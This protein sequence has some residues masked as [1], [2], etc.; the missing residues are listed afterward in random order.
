M[1]ELIKFQS[2]GICGSPSLL[3][4]CERCKMHCVGIEWMSHVLRAE[5]GNFVPCR[6]S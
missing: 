3:I 2:L 4:R 5:Y 6:I 1:R